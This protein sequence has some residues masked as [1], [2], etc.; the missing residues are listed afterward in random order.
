MHIVGR[1]MTSSMSWNGP[2]LALS[3][4]WMDS[5]RVYHNLKCT[6]GGLVAS[7]ACDHSFERSMDEYK[8]YGDKNGV[9]LNSL[10]SPFW[11]V[12][13]HIYLCAC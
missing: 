2:F 7:K 11:C 5:R 9:Q 12:C 10:Y 13:L 3:E 1:G 8:E 4:T 6:D